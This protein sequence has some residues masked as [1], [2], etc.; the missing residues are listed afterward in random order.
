MLSRAWVRNDGAGVP[1][2]RAITCLLTTIQLMVFF[3]RTAHG[4]ST[5]GYSAAASHSRNTHPYQGSCQGNGGGGGGATLFL[6]CEFPRV[7]YMHGKGFAARLILAFSSSIFCIIGV[8]SVNDTD[9][10]AMAEYPLE[11][12]E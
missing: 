7:D 12:A 10:F 4:D 8:L 6:E 1:V 5:T 11:S 2:L 9:L 3:L